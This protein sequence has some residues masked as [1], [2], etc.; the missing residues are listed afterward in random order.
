EKE[1]GCG[2]RWHLTD[3]VR[4]VA[5]P[6]PTG[7]PVRHRGAIILGA[8]RPG[9]RLWVA[10]QANAEWARLRPGGPPR[11]GGCWGHRKRHWRGEAPAGDRGG[12]PPRHGKSLCLGCLAGLEEKKGTAGACRGVSYATRRWPCTPPSAVSTVHRGMQGTDARRVLSGGEPS[13]PLS[14]SPSACSW[15]RWPSRRSH[16]RKSPAL[17]CY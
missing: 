2:W 8:L 7:A 14:P 9:P 15:G 16:Q 3:E 5:R 4:A 13:G 17:G 11:V 12:Q 6:G 1:E 10:L